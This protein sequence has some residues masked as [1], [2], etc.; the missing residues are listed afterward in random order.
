MVEICLVIHRRHYRMPELMKQLKEQTYQDFRVN[1]WNNTPSK[2]VDVRNLSS[3]RVKIINSETGNIG[4]C[5]RFK[6]AK[7]TK[8]DLIIFIDDDLI[9]DKD[10]IE[11]HVNMYKKYGAKCILGWWSKIYKEENY[12]KAM[13]W[14]KEGVEV[15]YIGTGGMIIS[16]KV[17]DEFIE[18]QD[19]PEEYRKVEDLYLSYLAQKYK[20]K[21]I[22]V[23]RRCNIYSDG[24][25]QYH[26]LAEYKQKAFLKLR[27]EGWKLLKDKSI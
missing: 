20:Y 19:M 13:V 21:L 26:K 25:D 14:L 10:F 12:H 3:S 7:E 15:D 4:S 23:D 24:Y 16:R 22:A 1:I 11:Y 6:L 9:L 18:L 27:K 17:I 2:N 8:G 5:A